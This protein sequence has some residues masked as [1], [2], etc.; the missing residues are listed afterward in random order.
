MRIIYSV[1]PYSETIGNRTPFFIVFAKYFINVASL[2]AKIMRITTGNRR[3]TN[4]Q[5]FVRNYAIVNWNIF[6]IFIQ[7]HGCIDRLVI[8]ERHIF[9]VALG[10]DFL[11][12]C[13]Q[14]F[15]Y[16]IDETYQRPSHSVFFS[17][18]ATAHSAIAFVSTVAG[19]HGSHIFFRYIDVKGVGM[20]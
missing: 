16:L 7:N 8:D 15:D 12:P 3:I 2:I 6:V 10:T 19:T 11:P 14:T 4:I 13:F 1:F 9:E 17:A 18:F 20:F 5:L